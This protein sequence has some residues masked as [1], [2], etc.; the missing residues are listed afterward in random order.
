LR[1]TSWTT[2]RASG[3][4]GRQAFAWAKLDNLEA[5][6]YSFARHFFAWDKLDNL[7]GIR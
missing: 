5:I 4:S 6:R 1:G 3:S 7:E 2:W